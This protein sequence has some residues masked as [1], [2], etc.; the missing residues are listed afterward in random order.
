MGSS[1]ERE[2]KEKGKKQ[3]QKK[4]P[5]RIRKI[6]KIFH[7]IILASSKIKDFKSSRGPFCLDSIGLVFPSFQPHAETLVPSFKKLLCW[8]S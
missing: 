8:P 2:R 1:S 4:K 7:D 6:N 3:K 5:V